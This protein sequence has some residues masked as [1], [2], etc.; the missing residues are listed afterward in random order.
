MSALVVFTRLDTKSGSSKFYATPWHFYPIIFRTRKL[1]NAHRRWV[2]IKF[3]RSKTIGFWQR[4]HSEMLRG[5]RKTYLIPKFDN[6][7]G[8]ARDF[9]AVLVDIFLFGV[10]PMLLPSL[11]KRIF[12]SL[13]RASFRNGSIFYTDKQPSWYVVVITFNGLTVYLIFVCLVIAL[14]CWW[15]PFRLPER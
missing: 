2:I 13:K 12:S 8:S 10:R 14:C 4:F 15:P 5:W 9:H 1:Q 7:T 11:R 6:Q 3:S